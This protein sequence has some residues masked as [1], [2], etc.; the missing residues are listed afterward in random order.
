MAHFSIETLGISTPIVKGLLRS[1]DPA[2]LTGLL[3]CGVGVRGAL[4]CHFMRPMR[5]PPGIGAMGLRHGY[6]P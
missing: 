1:T 4:V 5:S 3:Y 6:L 2:L